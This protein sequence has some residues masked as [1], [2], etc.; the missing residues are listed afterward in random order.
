MILDVQ[1]FISER[2]PDWEAFEAM[3]RR[4]EEGDRKAA[5]MDLDELRRFHYLYERVAADLTKLSAYA[6]E[7]RTVAYL[8]SLVARGFGETHGGA[9]RLPF[10][11]ALAQL[12]TAFPRVVRRHFQI[13]VAVV[14][15]FGTGM[16][17]GALA[18]ALD[19]TAKPVLMPFSHLLGDPSDRVAE[20]EAMASKEDHREGGKSS[21][22]AQLM[23]HNTRVAIFTLALGMTF[24][25]GTGVI[26]F[27][28][29]VMIGA[30]M[31]DYIL[32]GESVFL[33]G[34]LL[35]HG[36]VEIPAILLAGQGGLLLGKTLLFA[37]GR[38][39]LGQRLMEIRNDLVVLI[40]GIA[41]LLIWAGIIES[42]L[43]QYHEPILPYA[44]KIGFG[45]VQLLGLIAYLTLAGRAREKEG[46][47]R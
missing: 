24:G 4:L 45:A 38:K 20:E 13:F 15:I 41:V 5:R 29:G 31:M 44:A 32:A 42:F 47:A 12:V 11:R 43:S 36:S 27:Y 10:F 35:P 30:V 26:L 1:K 46:P 18:L 8:E 28:N 34:W 14:A 37:Q 39:S 23:T 6:V 3:L 21:F 22:S 19:E 25:I 16:I 33:A 17:F 7:P 9:R 40:G 2:R